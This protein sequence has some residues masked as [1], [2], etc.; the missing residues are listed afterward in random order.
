MLVLGTISQ[1][2]VTPAQANLDTCEKCGTVMREHSVCRECRVAV[3]LYC[4]TCNAKVWYD[5]HE[6]CYCQLELY[7][8]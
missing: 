1:K 5:T 2:M 6:F 7:S 3:Q 8:C 4:N